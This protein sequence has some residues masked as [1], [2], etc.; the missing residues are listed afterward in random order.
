MVVV[1]SS[2]NVMIP[3]LCSQWVSKIHF[4]LSLFYI[5]T[6]KSKKKVSK[7]IPVTGREGP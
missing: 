2:Y 6:K 5:N 7:G 4:S 1:I 3:K